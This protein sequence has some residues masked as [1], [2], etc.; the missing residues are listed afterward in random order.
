MPDVSMEVG[1]SG[2]Y[3]GKEGI[4]TVFLKILGS[5]RFA[6]DAFS[7]HTITTPYIEIAEDGKTAKGVFMSP[8]VETFYAHHSQTPP[9]NNTQTVIN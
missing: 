3:V 5:A 4:E 2:V 8:G 6:K 7:F 1:D 9:E